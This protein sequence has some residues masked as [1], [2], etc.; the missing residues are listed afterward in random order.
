MKK[1][2]L[3]KDCGDNRIDFMAEYIKT[4]PIFI[5]EFVLN[6]DKITIT[7]GVMDVVIREPKNIEFK[8]LKINGIT[9]VRTEETERRRRK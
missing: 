7:D 1:K 4:P 3:D 6:A 9:F 8:T 2:E 5:S